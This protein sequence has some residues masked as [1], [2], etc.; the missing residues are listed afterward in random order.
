MPFAG[1]G[2][3]HVCARAAEHHQDHGRES[4]GAGGPL[5]FGVRVRR[6]TEEER[7]VGRTLHTRLVS[8]SPCQR[9]AVVVFPEASPRE[10]AS[11]L[12]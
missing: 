12:I 4:Q 8:V 7:G 3:L 1:V 9:R 5:G 6:E 11:F 2:G 10:L